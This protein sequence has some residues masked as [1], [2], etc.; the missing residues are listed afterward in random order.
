MYKG[1]LVICL[2]LNLAHASAIKLAD[3]L[4]SG[5]GVTEILA[6][7]G[8]K[9]ADALQVQSYISASLFALGNKKSLSKDEF[10]KVLSALPVTGQDASIRKNLQVLLDTPAEQI[11]KS[12]IVNA[13]NSIISLANRYGRSIVIAC[14]SCVDESLAKNGFKFTVETVK[15][16]TTAKILNSVIPTNPTQLNI[17]IS[18]RMKKLGM[19]D[20]SKV[21]P[22]L[23]APEDEKSLA[24]FLSLA[25]SG[26]ADQKS[27]IQSIK[28]LSTKNG[29]INVV[30][31]KNP[32][33]FWKILVDDMS[34]EE[35]DGWTRTLEEVALRVE[36]DNITA[37]EAFYRTL[38]DKAEGNPNLVRNYETLKA[39]RCFFK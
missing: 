13:I 4:I 16:S 1:L 15:N 11:K 37:E 30:D 23:V 35:M 2:A 10:Y 12:D 24:I 18:A 3:Y 22:E 29:K 33:K 20:Y 27:L 6:K 39:K 28:K 14:A 7:E 25:E 34:P 31:S 26:T 36:K 17:Y 21:T 32:H 9:G 38:K 19:G 8:I 5:S